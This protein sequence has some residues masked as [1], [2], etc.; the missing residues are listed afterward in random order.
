MKILVDQN[1]APRLIEN[2]MDIFP[3]SLHINSIS[4]VL[5]SDQDIW[6]YALNNNFVLVTTDANFFD[7][8]ILAEKAPKT[9]FIKGNLIT[10]NKL[11]WTLRVNSESIEQFVDS[12]PSICLTIQA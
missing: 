10:T 9:I 3:D 7:Y 12:D 4:P 6:K 11:E 2:V 1:I 5:N 8:S